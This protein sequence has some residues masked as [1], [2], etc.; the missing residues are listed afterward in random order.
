MKHTSYTPEFKA[1]VV[2]EVISG[3]RSLN[4][5]AMAYELNPNML[6]TWKKEFT[7]NGF[8][9]IR[10]ICSRPSDPLITTV[11]SGGSDWLPTFSSAFAAILWYLLHAVGIKVGIYALAIHL[12]A[13]ILSLCVIPLYC[14]L[15]KRVSRAAAAFGA[16]SATVAPAYLRHALTGFFDTD[17]VIA[18]FALITVL[19]LYECILAKKRGEQIRYAVIT[20]CGTLLLALTWK[21]FYVYVAIAIGTGLAATGP[22]ANQV[23]ADY[24]RKPYASMYGEEAAQAIRVLYGGSVKG[25]NAAEFFGQPDIDGALVGGASLKAPDFTEIVKAAAA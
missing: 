11:Q 10:F 2:L 6:R 3:E 23:I 18:L 21:V 8:G 15:R 1:K 5:I 12:A 22:D 13:F 4:E 16:L 24:I 17:T 20:V 25:S 7:E 9:S 14:F 19:G